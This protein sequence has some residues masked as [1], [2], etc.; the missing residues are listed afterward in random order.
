MRLTL[1]ECAALAVMVGLALGGARALAGLVARPTAPLVLIALVAASHVLS[2]WLAPVHA[3][4]ALRFS[5]RMVAMAAFAWAVAAAPLAARRSA[6]VAITASAGL[7]ALLAVVEGVGVGLPGLDPWLNLF[8]ES[9]FNVGGTRRATAT[10]EYP[11]NAAA[12]LVC[13]I[14]AASGLTLALRR[15]RRLVVTATLLLTVGVLYTYSRGALL[16]AALGL[17][18]LWAALRRQDRGGAREPLVALGVLAATAFVFSTTR[19]VFRLRLEAEGMGTWY[20]AA[21]RAAENPLRLRPGEI[22]TTA[23]ELTNTGSKTWSVDEAFRLSHHW[24]RADGTMLRFDGARTALPRD[25]FPGQSVVMQAYV[26]APEKEG[27]YQLDWDMVHEHTTWFSEQGVPMGRVTAVVEGA[28]QA[29]IPGA[30]A[31]T[32]FVPAP[33]PWRPGRAELW[34]LA[35]AMWWERPLIGVGSDNFR[36]LYGPLAGKAAWDA[37]VYCNNTLLEA[38]ATTGALGLAAFVALLLACGRA[39]WQRL[40]GAPPGWARAEAAALLALL[41]ATVVHGLLDYFLAFTGH[42]LSFAFMVGALGA[43]EAGR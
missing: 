10:T 30:E 31:G 26:Q 42:Y 19:E 37:R 29:A 38:A 22:R 23:I 6:L 39:A 15:P 35:L 17:V 4:E 33:T 8:R 12:F 21:Y 41:A 36:R 3:A 18:A 16:A 28:G 14:A 2:G 25:M 20:R 27:R 1:L 7:V 24:R 34:R 40:R 5:G 13:G 32:Q 11:N 9:P 43:R